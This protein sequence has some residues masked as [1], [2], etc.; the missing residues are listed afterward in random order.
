MTDKASDGRTSSSK[1]QKNDTTDGRAPIRILGLGGKNVS[2][3]AKSAILKE[4]K[5]LRYIPENLAISSRTIAR[6][7]KE[8]AQRTTPF[9]RLLIYKTF[10]TTDGDL[11]LP[12]QNPLAMLYVAMA[13][14]D[15]Y[16]DR[17]RRA[18]ANYGPPSDDAPWT[19]A[20][21]VDEVTCGN[22]L[23]VRSDARR[24]VEG[25]YWALYQ[26]GA[27]SLSDE[28]CWFELAAFQTCTIR[29]FVGTVSHLLDVCLS[30][31]FDAQGHDARC[32]LSFFVK[33]HGKLML[34]LAVE[35]LIADIAALCEAIGAMGVS[36]TLPCFLC[37]R[38]LS[39]RSQ[40]NPQIAALTDFCDLSSLDQSK[41]GK[42]T[43][44]SL[45]KVLT[46][47][48]DVAATGDTKTLERKQT[49]CGY[50]HVPGNFLTNPL[51]IQFPLRVIMMDWMH[52]FFQSG[53][54]NREVMR[55]LLAA[56]SRTL[57]AYELMSTYVDA[58]VFPH[59]ESSAKSLFSPAHWESCKS[60][61]PPM[62][63][64]TASDG[65]TLYAVIGKFFQDVLLSRLAGTARCDEVTRMVTSYHRLCECVD[66]VQLSKFGNS[67]CPDLLDRTI[68]AW[69]LAHAVAYGT[70]L[71]YL[72]T[73][74]TS[75]LPDVLR[76]RG[77]DEHRKRL[78]MLIACWALDLMCIH[79]KMD[80]A[81]LAWILP[82]YAVS[83]L[84]LCTK[85]TSPPSH[86]TI[87]H[88]SA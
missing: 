51:T 54:W 67:V 44:A 65:L 1:R 64:G 16:S 47:L 60:A 33:G 6:A 53:N 43:N 30:C 42:H 56:T 22:P 48:K 37:R 31:F 57:N 72:K 68:G 17:V 29:T 38:V 69:R 73:H 87:R 8:V 83:F 10:S 41:W 82:I 78:A 24:K 3:A 75:H 84:H 32:G 9:G 85:G 77:R 25:V 5:G 15:R 34:T 28:S 79:T 52:L 26:L 76:A 39:W 12:V 62:F 4:L 63:K 59:N 2:M 21:Y 66:L 70:S 23:A 74:L 49:L 50:K 81:V 55:T 14:S 20:I 36:G 46:D 71:T 27:E 45:L 61:K 13:E 7:R 18:L 86:S 58:F 80:T 35:M 11:V 40:S 19:I 88:R